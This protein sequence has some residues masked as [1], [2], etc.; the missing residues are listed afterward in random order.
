[1]DS[2]AIEGALEADAKRGVDVTVIMTSDSDWDSAFSQLESDGVHVVLYPDTS[3]GSLHPREGDRRRQHK[4]IRRLGELL[5]SQPRL[6]P[7]VGRHHFVGQRPRAVEHHAVQRHL[8]RSRATADEQ[9]ST[10]HDGDPAICADRRP[11]RCQRGCSPIDDEGGCYEP[12]EYCRDDD[13]GMTGRAGDGQA[14]TCEDENGNWY[15]ESS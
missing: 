10:G 15:W 13:H 2:T 3:F 1:M 11:R 8:E 6:Q 12:G 14:I 7:G 9:P 5:D 4:G